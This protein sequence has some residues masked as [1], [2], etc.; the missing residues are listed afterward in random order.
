LA[1]FAIFLYGGSRMQPARSLC[2]FAALLVSL[3]GSARAQQHH[4]PADT[5]EKLGTVDFEISCNPAVQPVFNRGV[6]LLDSFWYEKAAETFSDAAA[7][8]SHCAMAYWGVAMTYYHPL[9]ASPDA[10]SL[11]AGWAAIEKAKAL[12][13]GTERERGYI[14]ALEM[15]YQD[16]DKLSHLTRV[17]AYERA[18]QQL[19]QRYPSD[20]ETTIF[21]ALALLGSAYTAPPDPAHGKQKEAG[22]M[23]TKIFQEEPDHPGVAHY[24][25]H[26]YDYPGLAPLALG[27]ARRYAKIAPDVPH[28]LHMPSHIFTRL[29]LWDE[30]IASNRAAAAAGRKYGWYGEELHATDYLMY[31]YL[32]EGRDREAE[33][34]LANL[35]AVQTTDS[36]YRAGLYAIEAMP[37]R[38]A[39]ERRRWREAEALEPPADF[40]SPARFAWTEAAIRFANG[41][42]AAR[43]GD[44]AK[45]QK[46]V[47]ELEQMRKTV[48]GAGDQ[49]WGGRL[50][51]QRDAV[52]AW[53]ALDEGRTQDALKE[54]R[55]AADREDFLGKDPVTPGAILPA[56]ELLADM[57]V[58]VHQPAHALAE[59][60]AVLRASPNRLNAL[61]G[62]ARAAELAGQ[63]QNA[64]DYYQS[65]LELCARAQGSR[66]ELDH[67]RQFLSQDKAL[68]N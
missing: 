33:R 56:R 10:A 64:R 20:R 22:A 67:A 13:A 21:Y 16:S 60:V 59:Y 28:A 57:L 5:V 7:K 18:M 34:L 37:A 26:S 29:G 8:D 52:A 42:G 9:W 27:A 62:A 65:L 46:A 2:L 48:L 38:Y 54:M 45:A 3:V 24:I 58:E 41:I 49:L 53:V 68:A 43:L 12:G 50:A 19:H 32:Q 6:A 36:N 61:Y 25:I 55:S 44:R 11:R 39:L 47:E 66:P 40:L 63:N 35:P 15:F 14:A 23:L 17:L 4:H 31:A 51:A 1:Q 30:S